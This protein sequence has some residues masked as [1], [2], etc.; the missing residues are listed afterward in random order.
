MS[1][2]VGNYNNTK[3]FI[4]HGNV[5]SKKFIN[6]A[7]LESANDSNSVVSVITGTKQFNYFAGAKNFDKA[8]SISSYKNDKVIAKSKDTFVE[9]EISRLPK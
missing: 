3:K 6:A 5:T 8:V 9:I 4:K 2:N 1:M 7:N